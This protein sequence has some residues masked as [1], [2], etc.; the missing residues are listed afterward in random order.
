MKK[1]E[2]VF[3]RGNPQLA[4]G[5]YE[6]KRKFKATSYLVAKRKAKKLEKGIFGKVELLKIQVV[7]PDGTV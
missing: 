7:K 5:G 2:A 4:N 3:W 6:T 1:F